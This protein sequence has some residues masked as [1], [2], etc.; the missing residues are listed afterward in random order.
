MHVANNISDGDDASSESDASLSTTDSESS[1]DTHSAMSPESLPQRY[2]VVPSLVRIPTATCDKDSSS[3]SSSG[4]SHRSID[5]SKDGAPAP[6]AGKHKGVALPA[7]SLGDGKLSKAPSSGS[8]ALRLDLAAARPPL[9]SPS[10]NSSARGSASNSARHS[11]RHRSGSHRGPALSV[12]LLSSAFA[13]DKH[14]LRQGELSGTGSASV[15]RQRAA[16]GLGVPS[17]ALRLFELREVP[18]DGD[19]Q[20]GTHRVAFCIPDSSFSLSAVEETMSDNKR[21]MATNSHTTAALEALQQLV[22]DQNTALAKLKVQA[23]ETSGNA[24][25]QQERCQAAENTAATL[26][27][28]L[29]RSEQLRTQGQAALLGIKQEVEA[30]TAALLAENRAGS[31]KSIDGVSPSPMTRSSSAR[32]QTAP[33]SRISPAVRLS[34]GEQGERLTAILER[35]SDEAVLKRLEHCLDKAALN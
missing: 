13:I 22:K 35:L 5:A 25:R 6:V 3:S 10:G 34:T 4:G 7:L 28:Q 32:R 14:T 21:L 17:T 30:L 15:A 24:R 26:R 33:E 12:D 9:R 27:Q 23:G 16:A 8:A 19:L 31:R 11:G 2:Q 20:P 1:T 29:E 18:H